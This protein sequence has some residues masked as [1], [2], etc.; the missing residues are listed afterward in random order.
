MD[1]H[2]WQH[3]EAEQKYMQSVFSGALHSKYLDM[4]EE[5]SALD[6]ASQVLFSEVVEWRSL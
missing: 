4:L 2:F 5:I 1:D 6:Q 3:M